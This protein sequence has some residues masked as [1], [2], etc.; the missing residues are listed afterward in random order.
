MFKNLKKLRD[1]I[2]NMKND[3]V[4]S[5]LSRYRSII[6]RING[7]NFDKL[8]EEELKAKS[9]ILMNKAQNGI[10]TDL[11]LPEAFAL[12]KETVKR[13]LGICPYDVQLLAG[14]AMHQGNIVQMQTGEGKTLAAVFPA[15]LN[16][17][18][19]KGVHILTFND[20]LVKR[21]AAWMGPIYELLGLTVG[22]VQEG[23]T[24]EERKTAYN[25]SITY[26]TA[27]EA[28]FDFL[29]GAICTEKE[30]LIQRPFH[31]AVIDEADSILIDEARIPLVIAGETLEKEEHLELADRLVNSL[32]PD[33]DFDTDEHSENVFLTDQGMDR[34]EKLLGCGNLYAPE[35]IELLTKLNN[36]LYARV[37]LKKDIDYIVRGDRIKLIDPFTGRIAANRHW[38]HGLQ[39]AVETKEGIQFISRG[40][41]LESITMQSFIRL[42]PRVS[43]MTGTAEAAARE[44][45]G[46]YGLKVVIIPTHKPSCR[47][48]LHDL[49]FTHETVKLKFV[50]D[51]VKRV[52]EKGQPVLIGTGSVEE[53]EML[54]KALEEVGV[55]CNVLNA[56]NDEAEAKII[57]DAGRIGAVTVSTNMAGRGVD[58]KL[59]GEKGDT[60]KQVE[61][62]GG[63]YVI[64]TTRHESRRIDDQLRGRAG[65]QGDPGNT[66]FFISLEDPLMVKHK[67]H[68]AIPELGKIYRQEGLVDDPV[69]GKKIASAQR[70][71]EGNHFDIRMSLF[72]YTYTIEKQRQIIH[73][74]RMDLLLDKSAAGD[75]KY[76]E[77]VRFKR[78][79][80]HVSGR[81]LEKAQK[82]SA[83]FFLNKYWSDYLRYIA[84]VQESIYLVNIGGKAPLDEF[85]RIAIA[86][87]DEMWI[88]INEDI[89][90]LLSTAEITDEGI[91]LEREGLKGPSAAWTYLVKDNTEQLGICEICRDPI[92]A[93]VSGPLLVTLAV[94]N[95]FIKKSKV[96]K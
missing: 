74:I 78:L 8:K 64:G 42:Y 58:I 94:Y 19:G 35:N 65:R 22:Y 18:S 76:K 89:L 34:I 71:I 21:D 48:D 57:A 85:N 27:K 77:N 52:H 3:S 9:F 15:Y 92:A 95:R 80:R 62:L 43:G 32:Q 31:F 54:A 84:S 81:G 1:F 33:I 56:K 67:M 36:A 6:E 20:Y 2:R 63:L 11:L 70:R 53:S 60:Q 37:L 49:V 44:F 82:Q 66:R 17:L 55:L 83:L 28:G 87:Y 24:I 40:K 12:V 13:Q 10:F 68:E 29:R 50:V 88:K 91:D 4:I 79:C 14:I 47:E 86:A 59:G 96:I 39:A 23:M 7:F 16:A 51:E 75:L 72:K 41:I 45:E 93:A 30:Q 90:Y 69:I 38:P 26:L 25:C 5:D 46:F 61:E 73:G